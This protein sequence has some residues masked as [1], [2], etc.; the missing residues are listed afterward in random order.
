MLS[1]MIR[2]E[3]NGVVWFE[4]EKL[5]P[6]T[7]FRH[8]VFSRLGGISEGRY[9]SL[10]LSISVGDHPDNVKE[11]RRRAFDAI[12]LDAS[13]S[14]VAGHQIHDAHVHA[15]HETPAA[16]H[17][18]AAFHVFD[19]C[20]AL[21][22]KL[23]KTALTIQHA[24]CQAGILYDPK[25]KAF[26]AIHSGWRGSVKNIYKEAVQSLE[27]HYGSKAHDL[28]ACI[29]PSLGPER[30]EFINYQKELPES[31]LPFETKP[32]YFDFWKISRWQLETLGVLPHN[33]EVAGVCTYEDTSHFFSYRREKVSG[34]HLTLAWLA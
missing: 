6:Y 4:F 26:A 16:I 20:D 11:N 8:A 22:T 10:N 21:T 7:E 18:P 29:S 30:A 31:F 17:V 34:R 3:K 9:A 33:I 14:F 24:D 5:A 32:T 19:R 23:K 2:K 12:G 28:I 25:Q 15:I 13:V 27:Q 1:T